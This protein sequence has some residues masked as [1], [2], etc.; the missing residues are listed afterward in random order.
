[1]KYFLT[2]E[3]TILAIYL[4]FILIKFFYKNRELNIRSEQ[5]SIMNKK[6]NKQID[7]NIYELCEQME[8]TREECEEKFG[9]NP[10]AE[11]EREYPFAG[12]LM[13]YREMKAN[14]EVIE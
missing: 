7:K 3:Y 6:I 10:H 2:I 8:K 12:W 5:L 14:N 11:K 9:I 4:I 13:K 1:M